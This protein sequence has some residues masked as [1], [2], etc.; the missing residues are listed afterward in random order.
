M[1]K[2]L[3]TK[4]MVDKNPP[5][6]EDGVIEAIVGSTAVIDRMGDTIDQSGWDLNAL[7]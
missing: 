4:A 7:S 3:H 5:V 2:M 6:T 1:S